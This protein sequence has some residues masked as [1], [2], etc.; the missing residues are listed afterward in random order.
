[1]NEKQKKL[2]RKKSQA[3]F[4]LIEI[5]IV[6]IIIGLLASLVGPRLFSQL[7]KAKKETAKSQISW[8]LTT[9][10]AYR[11]DVGTYPSTNEGLDALV[12]NPGNDSWNGPYLDKN[13]PPDPWGNPYHYQFPGEHGEVD[14][15]SYGADNKP[16]GDGENA[17][18]VSWE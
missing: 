2:D 8:L 1:M 14:L 5:M 13:V 10:D 17:D 4:S 3:G 6:M 11:L 12:Q 16:G 7:G 15:Y 9:L 18:V